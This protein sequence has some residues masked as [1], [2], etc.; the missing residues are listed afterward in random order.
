MGWFSRNISVTLI[1]DATGSVF[2]TTDMPP[3]D[4]PE[5]FALETTLHIG[6]VDWSVVDAVPRTRP[7]FSKSRKLTLRLRRVEKIDPSKILFSLPSICDRIPS[8]GGGPLA[9]DDTAFFGLFT[10]PP[11]LPARTFA[12]CFVVIARQYV[13][14]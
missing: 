7:E 1:D 13:P 5:T 14:A 8:V 2:A 3:A 9:A 4:L 12:G 10:K 11:S 6:D